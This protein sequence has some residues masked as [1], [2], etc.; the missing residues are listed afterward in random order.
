MR[1][2]LCCDGDRSD[3]V[4]DVLKVNDRITWVV[5][6]LAQKPTFRQRNILPNRADY[7]TWKYAFEK[8]WLFYQVWGRLMYD[9]APKMTVFAHAFNKKYNIDFGDKLHRRHITWP[10]KCL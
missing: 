8:Q 3:F 4:R 9:P 2:S 6:K 7:L 10:I 1:I 5:L